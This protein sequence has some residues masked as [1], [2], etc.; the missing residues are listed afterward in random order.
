MNLHNIFRKK[1]NLFGKKVSIGKNNTFSN[2]K[3][4]TV[5]DYVYIGN[6]NNFSLQ[7]HVYIASGTIISDFCDFRTGEHCYEDESVNAVPFDL[8]VIYK[9]II[10]NKNV[11]IGCHSILLP[12]V[13]IGEGAV[14]GAG[15]VVTKSVPLLAIVGGNPARIIKFRN[16]EFYKKNSKTSFMEKMYS[17][18]RVLIDDDKIK[19][20][21]K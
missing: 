6:D 12:G 16:P 3:N 20:I 2:L 7:G 5:E 19:Q 11:W 13:E 10:I 4:I 17:T 15:S 14:I 1:R 9:N 8:R 21:M 18:K